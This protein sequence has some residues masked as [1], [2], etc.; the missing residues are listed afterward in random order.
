MHT[1]SE[2]GSIRYKRSASGAPMMTL[3]SAMDGQL[4]AVYEYQIECDER[5]GYDEQDDRQRVPDSV[6]HASPGLALDNCAT[7]MC[8]LAFDSARSSL[9]ASCWRFARRCKPMV[10]GTQS[11]CVFRTAS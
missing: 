8:A 9:A 10:Y 3:P 6:T 7:R 11:T 4:A 5:R 1:G 2:I